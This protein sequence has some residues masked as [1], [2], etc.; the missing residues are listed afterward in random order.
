MDR[1]AALAFLFLASNAYARS[2]I[3]VRVVEIKGSAETRAA[4]DKPW[5]PLKEG[6]LLSKGAWIQTG[7]RSRVYLRFGDNTVVQ[8]KS[9]TLLQ[10]SEAARENGKTTGRLKLALGNVHVEVDKARETVDFKVIT[11]QVTT[12]VKGTGFDVRSYSD[13]ASSRIDVQHG[14]VNV[15]NRTTDKDVLPGGRAD[16]RLLPADVASQ[17]RPGAAPAFDGLAQD[18]GAGVTTTLVATR[19]MQFDP[20]WTM[21]QLVTVA[22]TVVGTFSM[23]AQGNLTWSDG[24]NTLTQTDGT[25]TNSTGDTTTLP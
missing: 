2:E 16:S 6:A 11:P 1:L 4:A 20:S 18:K 19:R 9:A 17:V 8:V 25:W 7:L 22:T 24:T 15:D 10:I 14:R 21:N 12:S 23:D 13:F 3:Q 5:S